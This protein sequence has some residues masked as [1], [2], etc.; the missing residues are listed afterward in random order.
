[1]LISAFFCCIGIPLN[2]LR[3]FL[4]FFFIYI[5]KLHRIFFHTYNLFIFYKIYIS[6]I[7]QHCRNIGCDHTS[8]FCLSHDQRTVFSHCIKFIRMILEH[9]PKCIGP[10]YSMHYLCN[11]LQRVSLIIVIQKMCQYF[12]ICLRHKL[13][14]FF[15]QLL[16]EF[17]IVFN[18]SIVHNNNIFIFVIMW[19]CIYI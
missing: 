4:D 1:M 7:F 9:D 5:E 11:R 10:F 18:N 2:M 16:F 19:M 14:P 6:C 12:G 3:S 15:L 8:V 17:Q 13:I